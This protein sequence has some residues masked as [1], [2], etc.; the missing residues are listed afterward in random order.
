MRPVWPMRCAA[1]WVFDSLKFVVR[2]CMRKSET[3]GA[4][5]IFAFAKRHPFPPAKERV[6]NALNT[7]P[8]RIPRR[9]GGET[10]MS[11]PALL[12]A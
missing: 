4:P 6:T 9:L 12:E 1:I 8:N 10:A 2:A 3:G 7:H 11:R 5:K